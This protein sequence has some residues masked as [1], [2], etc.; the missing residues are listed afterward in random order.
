MANKR[1]KEL[2]SQELENENDYIVIDDDFKQKMSFDTILPDTSAIIDGFLSKAIESGKLKVKTIILHEA[3]FAE[4]ESQANKNRETGYLGLEELIRLQNIAKKNKILID[5][6]GDRPGE[7]EIRR[8]KSGEIDN[9]IRDTADLKKATLITGD[10]VQSLVAKAKAIP[11]VLLQLS[12][13]VEKS[14]L[15]GFFDDR[16]MS[17]H[18]KEEC[19]PKA[20]KGFP[21]K[22][23]YDVIGKKELTRDE[24]INLSKSIVEES[25]MRNDAFIE[26]Q[27]KGSSIIQLGNLR[28]VI[29]KPPFSEG[30]EITAVRPIKKLSLDEYELPEKLMQRFEEQAE[31]VLISGAP[32]QGKSTFAQALAEF[33]NSRGKVVKTVEAPRDLILSNEITQYSISHGSSEE[34]HD[35]LLL[36]RPDYTFFDEM[37]NPTDF[38]LFADMRLSGVGMLGVIHATKTID[39]IQRF[40]GKIDLGVIPHVVDT[41]IFIQGGKI[42]NVYAVSMKVKVPNGMQE[43]DLARPVICVN[44]FYTDKLEFEIYTYGEQTVVMPVT[45]EEKS[46]LQ[47]LAEQTLI[48]YFK[49]FDSTSKVEMLTDSRCAVYVSKQKRP[50]L[51]GRDGERIRAIEKDIGISV[52]IRPLDDFKHKFDKSES[53]QNKNRNTNRNNTGFDAKFENKKFKKSNKN[54]QRR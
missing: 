25:N 32:G 43:S 3:M 47:K 21:G 40:I 12:G 52:D 22:W 35:V 17:V 29:T 54:K 48:N 2:V 49:Q 42:E 38:K 8:A 11:V 7:F 53:F 39:A 44:D 1:K 15:H 23:T 36:S 26:I 50:A 30:Y 9:L 45:G 20:K 27:R 34:V 16:T 18:L 28:I 4:L 33:Y 13:E 37:R 10:I 51:I 19:V 31:G 24:L 14:S 41:V 46:S 5:K 6:I